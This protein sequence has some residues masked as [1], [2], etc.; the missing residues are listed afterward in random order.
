MLNMVLTQAAVQPY[1]NKSLKL[2]Q[3]QLNQDV[4]KLNYKFEQTAS[5][6]TVLLLVP[7]K[8]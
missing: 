1:L 4:S 7:I 3:I 8:C 5:Q 2:A 6:Y